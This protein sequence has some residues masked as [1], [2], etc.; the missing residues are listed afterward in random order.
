MTRVPETSTT[1]IVS[2][3]PECDLLIAVA[4]GDQAAFAALYDRMM[5]RVLG[6]IVQLLRDRSQSEEV[7]QDV[8]L[9]VWQHA[10]RFDADRG[11]AV[12]WI[13]QR[14]HSR[15][16]DRVRS[17]AASTARDRRIGLVDAASVT[18]SVEHIVEVHIETMKVRAA[19]EDLSVPQRKAIELCHLGGYTNAEAA[20]I[21]NVPIGT[22]KTRIRDGLARLRAALQADDLERA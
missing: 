8:M 22:V 11:T 2:R 19:L 13:L 14:A 21:L 16:V 3:A 6:L 12:G 15:A 20:E 17:A 18:D 10:P 4:A 7:A 5:P 1:T 9:E